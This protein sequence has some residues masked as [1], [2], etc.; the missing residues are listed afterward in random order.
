MMITC[1]KK[2]TNR[3]EKKKRRKEGRRERVGGWKEGRK[4]RRKVACSLGSVNVKETPARHP[5]LT[6]VIL[7]TK[8]WRI[9]VRD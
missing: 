5:W 9:M 3:K 6:P 7:A 1:L 2:Q 4:E 8:I